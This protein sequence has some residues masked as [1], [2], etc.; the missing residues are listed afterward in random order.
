MY[1]FPCG[2]SENYVVVKVKPVELT[3]IRHSDGYIEQSEERILVSR[4]LLSSR[5][6]MID[7]TVTDLMFV[8][9]VC[10][11]QIANPSEIK[12]TR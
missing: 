10:G 2:H 3:F 5:P 12:E 6:S 11:K 9:P 7:S 1:E 4:R 8:C